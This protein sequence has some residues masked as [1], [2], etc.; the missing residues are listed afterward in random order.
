MMIGTEANRK[1]ERVLRKRQSV[2]RQIGTIAGR[3]QRAEM[4]LLSR[5][6]YEC[7]DSVIRAD[8]STFF[9]ICEV[10]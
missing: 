10:I 3:L 9:S 7:G 6:G 8:F 5:R 4:T 1:V 2:L